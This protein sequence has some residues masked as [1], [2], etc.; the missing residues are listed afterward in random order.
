MR[1]FGLNVIRSC[2]TSLISMIVGLQYL[3]H[4]HIYIAFL[5]L[6]RLSAFSSISFFIV[7]KFLILF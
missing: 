2:G 6:K 4:G 3:A 7:I 1:H 5:I